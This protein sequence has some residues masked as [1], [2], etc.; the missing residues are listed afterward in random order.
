MSFQQG[1]SGLNAAARALDVASNNVANAATVGFKSSRAQFADIYAGTTQTSKGGVQ[2]GVGVQLSTISKNF[3]QGG[4]TVTQ[5][6]LDMAIN[7]GGFFRVTTPG[8]AVAYSRNGQF[9]LDNT[10]R[11]VDA[12][13]N[14]LTGYQSLPNGQLATGSTG[15]LSIPAGDMSPRQTER[16]EASFN[17]DAAAVPP[18]SP[19][20][21]TDPSSYNG[22]AAFTVYDSLGTAHQAQIF[23]R[24]EG[25]GQWTGRIAVNGSELPGGPQAT[26]QFDAGGIMTSGS[27]STATFDPANG[28]AVATIQMDFAGT[29][30][31]SGATATNRLTQDGY[32]SGR[33]TGVSVGKDGLIS[34][35]YS[36]GMTRVAGQVVLSNFQ[37]PQGL[38]PLGG[39][40]FAQTAASGQPISGTP[41]TGGL[42]EL[43]SGVIEESNVDL[44]Q[45][46]I[47][48]II[49]QR[50]YQ[51]N[52]QSIKT[53]D[54]L[55]QTLINLR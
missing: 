18:A 40:L 16:V 3:G 42:G 20:S 28:A 4:L 9:D 14:V 13:G 19:F 33:P 36:N 10:G 45:E 54:S 52:A 23:W 35:G 49:A 41:M 2:T 46:M 21:M 30:Q 47:N 53:Q 26:L 5:N 31:F 12:G 29:T 17:L 48:M 8:G 55:M 11:I 32:A 51:A 25:G 1:L 43:N 27:T 37:S 7:G 24:S 50:N 34:V 15:P 38:L 44:T 39:N 22:V 6:P